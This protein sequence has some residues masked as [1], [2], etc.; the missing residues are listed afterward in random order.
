MEMKK[1]LIFGHSLVHWQGKK[2]PSNLKLNTR[3]FSVQFRGVRGGSLFWKPSDNKRFQKKSMASY[4]CDAIKDINPHIVYL[5]VGGND[6]DRSSVSVTDVVNAT[7]SLAEFLLVAYQVEKVCIGHAFQRQKS[8]LPSYNIRVREHNA[9]VT[10]KVNSILDISAFPNRG[11]ASVSKAR[12]RKDGV[13][14]SNTGISLWGR[15]L[16]RTIIFVRDTTL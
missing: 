11:F 10:L 5:Q 7:L 16:R 13:H 4:L 6:L 12:Y 2:Y 8:K 3:E 9:L 15:N 1:V 14:L